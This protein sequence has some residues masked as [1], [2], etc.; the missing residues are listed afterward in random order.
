MTET[1]QQVEVKAQ[2]RVY[3]KPS[4]EVRPLAGVVNG[5]GSDDTD[6]AGLGER[7]PD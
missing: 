6:V 2:R 5:I 3:S 7:D 4:V 1:K